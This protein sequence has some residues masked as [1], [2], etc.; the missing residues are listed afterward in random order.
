[1]IPSRLERA[2]LIVAA[3]RA[4]ALVLVITAAAVVAWFSF[5]R[6]LPHVITIIVA[7]ALVV[8]AV[9]TSVIAVVRVRLIA[10]TAGKAVD[11]F[12]QAE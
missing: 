7:T 5:D 1:M 6:P 11:I 2:S 4:A 12:T 10:R 9:S 8:V 3:V